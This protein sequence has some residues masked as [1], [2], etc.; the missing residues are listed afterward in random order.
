M[1]RGVRARAAAALDALGA[2]C[3]RSRRLWGHRCGL[4][5]RRGDHRLGGRGRLGGSSSRDDWLAFG[6]LGRR[7]DRRLG[8][9]WRRHRHDRLLAPLGSL[10]A[11]VYR[12]ALVDFA[13][14]RLVVGGG[15]AAAARAL[16]T[17]FA[18][19]AAPD[20]ASGARKRALSRRRARRPAKRLEPWRPSRRATHRSQRM[21]LRK[22][23]R[24]SWW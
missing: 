5:C 7:L 23:S 8:W 1:T 3:E 18:V 19:A 2:G 9:R 14:A 4:G 17:G 11:R 15:L 10:R 22:R 20:A 21:D 16:E 24:Q 13:R 12:V 6:R